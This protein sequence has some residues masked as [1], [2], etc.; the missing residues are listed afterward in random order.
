M[1]NGKGSFSRLIYHKAR[2][3]KSPPPS[4]RR[5]FV[6]SMSDLEYWKCTW[7]VDIL[8]YC[9]CHPDVEFMFLSKSVWAYEQIC[10]RGIVWPANTMQGL[11]LEQVPRFGPL[12]DLMINTPRPYLSIEPILGPICVEPPITVELVIVGGMTG[13]GAV[14]VKQEWIDSVKKRV[15]KDKLYFKGELK[16]R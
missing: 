15:D 4:A 11:T 14:P 10:N 1:C 2:M 6:G 5:V 3:K 12:F 13:P 16:G 7:L 8:T 9:A